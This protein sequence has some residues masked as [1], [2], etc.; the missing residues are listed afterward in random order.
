MPRVYRP[1]RCRRPSAHEDAVATFVLGAIER[2]VGGAQQIALVGAVL[3]KRRHA[4]RERRAQRRV[5]AVVDG[6]AERGDALAKPLGDLPGVRRAGTREQGAE[7]LVPQAGDKIRLA[8]TGRE[9][10]RHC[11]EKAVAGLVAVGVADRLETVSTTAK[12]SR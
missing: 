7:L 10:L 11:D 2:L 6:D 5:G 12:L 9:L 3:R 8:Q 4:R 1:R